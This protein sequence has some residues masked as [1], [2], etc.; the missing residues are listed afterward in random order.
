MFYQGLVVLYTALQNSIYNMD[1]SKM[2]MIM[3]LTVLISRVIVDF[4]YSYFV[5]STEYFGGSN[6]EFIASS[7]LYM[8]IVH[9]S[10]PHLTMIQHVLLYASTLLVMMAIA[11]VTR[12]VEEN[13]ATFRK[14]GV[15]N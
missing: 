13:V 6:L 9:F 15:K 3:V 2:P 14:S 12:W 4:L 7:I 10:L 1:I 5:S 11:R 8:V